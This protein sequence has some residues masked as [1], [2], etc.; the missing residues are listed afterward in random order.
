MPTLGTTVPDVGIVSVSLH[1]DPYLLIAEDG[2]RTRSVY[3]FQPA[4]Q[5]EAHYVHPSCRL[6]VILHAHL[7]V[8]DV[9]PVPLI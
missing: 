2:I 9:S 8:F 6:S 1:F 4:Y 3:P 7:M 5:Q